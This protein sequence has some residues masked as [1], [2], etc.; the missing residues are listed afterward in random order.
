MS[1]FVIFDITHHHYCR[2]LPLPSVWNHPIIE[3]SDELSLCINYIAIC[4]KA[5]TLS[6]LGTLTQ[7]STQF[8]GKN[9]MCHKKHIQIFLNYISIRRLFD[10]L[11]H[12]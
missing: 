2:H 8:K 7:L 3:L 10:F 9:L 12:H 4:I 11:V 5:V 1:S 6:S